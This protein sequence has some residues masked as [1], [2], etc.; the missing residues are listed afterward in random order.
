LYL[1][2]LKRQIVILKEKEPFAC[3]SKLTTFN[4]YFAIAALIRALSI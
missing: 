3:G 4:D 1:I 2:I